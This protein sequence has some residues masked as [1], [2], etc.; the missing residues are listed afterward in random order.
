MNKKMALP[1]KSSKQKR[2]PT[3]LK[4]YY[5]RVNSSISKGY[6][7]TVYPI[8]YVLS[9]HSPFEQHLRYTLVISSNTEPQ[10]FEQVCHLMDVM[11]KEIQALQENNTWYLIDLSAEK[12]HIRCKWVYKIKH[13]ADGTIK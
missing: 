1:I 7:D 6:F 10:N 11:K 2:I 3:F 13:K 5:H 9:Y 4:D 12:T 8:T